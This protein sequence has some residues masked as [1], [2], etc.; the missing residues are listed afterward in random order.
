VDLLSPVD[1]EG[2]MFS[3][4]FSAYFREN[5]N[6]NLHLLN[7]NIHAYRLCA[8]G[9]KII[10]LMITTIPLTTIPLTTTLAAE[11]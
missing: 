2:L 8:G 10:I 4:V 1:I 11:T 7:F 3:D 5:N 6:N 9:P